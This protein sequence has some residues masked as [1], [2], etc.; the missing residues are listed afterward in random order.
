MTDTTATDRRDGPQRHRADFPDGTVVFLIGMRINRLRSVRAWLPV[1]TAMPKMLKELFRHPELGL[2]EARSTWAG[3]NFTVI[4]YWE[5]MDKLMTYAA[6]RDHAHLP[7]WKA[8][9]R[10]TQE[11]GDA[12]GIWHE[13][14]EASPQR[15]HIVYRSMPPIGMGKATRRRTDRE[16]PPQPVPS[17]LAPERAEHAA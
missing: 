9:N 14:Y 17:R 8:F 5:S 12:V 10:M 13:A 4:Q 16:M 6:S 2:L 11:A 3:R 1:F 15:S 7:A